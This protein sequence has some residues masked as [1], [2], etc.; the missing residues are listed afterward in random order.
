VAVLLSIA[1]SD[2]SGGAGVQADIKVACDF[3]VFACAAITAL[4]VQGPRGVRAVYPVPP[5]AVHDQIAAVLDEVPVAAIKVGMLGTAGTASAVARALRRRARGVP[6]VLDP[7]LRSSSGS[8][9]LDPDGVA[10]LLADLLPEVALLTPNLPERAALDRAAGD[11]LARGRDL[12]V[13]VLLKGGHAEGDAIADRLLLPDGSER[14]FRHVRIA[15]PNTHGTG[16]A[17][18]AAAAARLAYG[19]DI[20]A[21]V[22]TAVA[23]VEER[24][25]AGAG[26]LEV[27]GR[28]SMPLGLRGR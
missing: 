18:S 5:G 22:A 11:L 25:E 1:G 12:G 28:G 19:D 4:T 9:L 24:L 17:L 10:A 16:C 26:W 14:V 27:G 15:T 13:A 3:G 21:A 20:T 23:Y 6:V 2:P 8:P 7:V